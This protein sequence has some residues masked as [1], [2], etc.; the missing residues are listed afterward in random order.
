M[1]YGEAELAAGR[2]LRSCR[3]S[4]H[5]VFQPDW[6]LKKTLDYSERSGL[7]IH[8]KGISESVEMYCLDISSVMFSSETLHHSFF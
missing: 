5:G 6:T 4:E 8:D 7:V 2:D 3:F 1:S